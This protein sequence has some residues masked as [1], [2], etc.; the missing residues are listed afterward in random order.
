MTWVEYWDEQPTIYVNARHREAHYRQV[1]E[2]IAAHIDDEA[3]RV[4]DYGCG[5]ALFAS[6][7]AE[8]CAKLFLCEAAPSVRRGLVDNFAEHDGIEVVS[9]E[10]EG[11]DDASLDLIVVNSVLQYLDTEQTSE[12][13]ASCRRL[14]SSRG[15]LLLADVIP[16]SLGPSKDARALLAFAA[17]HGFLIAATTGL[18]KTFFSDYRKRRAQLGFATFDE[19]E[20]IALLARHGFEASRTRPNL[21]HNQARMA[22]LATRGTP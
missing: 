2:G 22:F 11:I 20:L 21:G 16:P 1:A 5:E 7:V 17:R 6:R 19:D 9:P 18:A 4:L 14:L 8:R 10:F 13:F 3:S 12:L 15:R